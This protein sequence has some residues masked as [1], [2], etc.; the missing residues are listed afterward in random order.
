M[1][2]HISF[3]KIYIFY[4]TGFNGMLNKNAKQNIANSMLR[5]D[6]KVC[7]YT[8][9]V[10]NM[11]LNISQYSQEN[12]CVVF[13][14]LQSCRPS[15]LQLYWNENLT[16]MFFREYCKIFKKIYF[17]EHL[18]TTASKKTKSQQIKACVCKKS[19]KE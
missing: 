16:Q 19:A 13:S 7:T 10:T 4:F 17:Q 6:L 1:E 15:G 11:F 2:Q 3:Y 5:K 14:F 8:R 12:T 18:Q 9:S